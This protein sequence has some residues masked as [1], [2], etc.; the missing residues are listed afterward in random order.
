M[1]FVVIKFARQKWFI[2]CSFTRPRCCYHPKMSKTDRTPNQ[3]N[4]EMSDE[5]AK[6]K[7]IELV[8]K[9]IAVMEFKLSY[10]DKLDR[11]MLYLEEAM[12]T[13]RCTHES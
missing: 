12:K 6:M 3:N 8:K 13:K 4:D 2:F 9:M 1:F 10:Y 7:C 5:E 11:E